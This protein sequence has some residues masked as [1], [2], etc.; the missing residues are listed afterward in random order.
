MA[1]KLKRE[2][3]ERIVYEELNRFLAEKFMNEAPPGAGTVLDDEIPDPDAAPEEQLPTDSPAPEAGDD[4]SMPDEDLP[5]GEEPTDDDLEADLAGED[6][7]GAEEG[8][9]GYELK[10]KTIESATIEEDSKI[11]PGATE[12]VL[13][14]ADADD[15]LR[16]LISKT[17]K[18]KIFYKGLHNDFTSPIEQI[19]GGDEPEQELGPEGDEFADLD[20]PPEGDEELE[21][22]PPLGP[23]DMGGEEPPEEPV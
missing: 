15:A 22:M 2:Q 17:G 6:D 5:T 4:I 7:D 10:H 20:A 9:V 1:L 19:P 8:T 16:L 23:D 14:F 11:M 13:T 3:L 18:V 21:D 12:V